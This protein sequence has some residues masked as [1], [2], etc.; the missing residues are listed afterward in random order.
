MFI[1]YTN[2]HDWRRA[3]RDYLISLNILIFFICLSVLYRKS[4]SYL[5]ETMLLIKLLFKR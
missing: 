5:E 2:H 3:R 4:S 1:A